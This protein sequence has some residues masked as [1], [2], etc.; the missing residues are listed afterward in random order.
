[1]ADPPKRPRLPVADEAIDDEEAPVSDA[2]PSSPAPRED[3]LE[4]R[5]P[6]NDIEEPLPPDGEGFALEDAPV[7][8]SPDAIAVT[9]ALT[10]AFLG[11]KAT[12]DR[13]RDVVVY[14]APRHTQD[15]DVRDMIQE[16]NMRVL[17][18][19][20]LAR[21]V[22]GMRPWVSR[23]AQNTVIDHY[24]GNAKHLKWLD[25]SVEVQELPPDDACD[26]V[27]AE[28]P[29]DDP[30]APPRPIEVID[31]RMLDRWLDKNVTT[32]ADRL[33]LEMIRQKARK[34]QTNAEVAA[35][36]GIT[37]RAYYARV[38]RFKA[39]WVPRWKEHREERN[40]TLML[41]LLVAGALVLLALAW[42]L[43]R[44]TRA[45]IGPAAVPVLEPVPTASA[46]APQD[47]RFNQA[48]PTNPPPEEQGKPK[49]KP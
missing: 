6:A 32:K 28:L 36:Y 15:A 5:G 10:S 4:R 46:S 7:P 26:G 18:A 35:E 24:R 34:K 29:P 20:S 14:R 2:R 16:A 43:L 21:S 27:D 13:I 25:R 1:M 38:E 37:E 45:D 31:P 12:Q 48:D 44:P 33:T 8:A 49:G 9:R 41:L 3:F 30:T 17:S 19:T 11:K 22:A 47:D 39:E 40:R 23:I 42:W